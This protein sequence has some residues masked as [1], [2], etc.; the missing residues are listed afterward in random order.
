MVLLASIILLASLSQS[1]GR[2][3][4]PQQLVH[5]FYTW[6]FKIYNELGI[7]A[8]SGEIYNY[9]DRKLVDYV[10]MHDDKID[11]F[12]QMGYRH[13]PWTNVKTI[14]GNPIALKNKTFALPVTFKFNWG[15]WHVVVFVEEENNALYIVRVMDIFPYS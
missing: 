2:S 13:A 4:N 1:H 10:D 9:V 3:T 5:D 11:Y 15:K 14:V 7:Y 12:T 6:Y 8:R